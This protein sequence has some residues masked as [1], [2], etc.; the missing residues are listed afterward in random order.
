MN[1]S[2]MSG[3]R[4]VRSPET[5]QAVSEEK[6]WIKDNQSPHP[7]Q[8]REGLVEAILGWAR[9]EPASTAAQG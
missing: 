3:T 4:L 6:S 9:A 5:K 1:L 8:Q 2:H 7:Q